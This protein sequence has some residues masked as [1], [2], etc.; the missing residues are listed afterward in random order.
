MSSVIGL[1]LQFQI[2]VLQLAIG[3]KVIVFHFLLLLVSYFL[4]INLFIYSF[5]LPRSAI[6]QLQNRNKIKLNT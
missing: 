5:F 4:F 3:I 6:S 1:F 2:V